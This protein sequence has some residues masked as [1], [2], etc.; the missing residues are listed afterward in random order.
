MDVSSVHLAALVSTEV[1][2]A[3]G[4][5][6]MAVYRADITLTASN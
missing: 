4:A 3:L 6:F 2:C 5:L 1:F